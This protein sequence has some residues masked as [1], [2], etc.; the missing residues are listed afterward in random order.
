MQ[1]S[2]AQLNEIQLSVR[3]SESEV[4]GLLLRYA[5]GLK[6]KNSTKRK[7]DKEGDGLEADNQWEDGLCKEI[8]RRQGRDAEKVK[9]KLLQGKP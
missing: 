6:T 1:K 8:I 2:Q 3:F 9:G 4:P 7:Q 5:Q